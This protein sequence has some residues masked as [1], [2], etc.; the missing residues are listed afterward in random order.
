MNKR[1]FMKGASL[2]E[3]A[4]ILPR[5]AGAQALKR[6]PNILIVI[7]DD[8]D[9]SLLNFMGG[10]KGLMPHVEALTARSHR[11]VNA[12][13]LVPICQP[14]REA[15]LSGKLPHRSGATGFNPMNEGTVTLPMILQ[16]EGYFAAAIRKI[17]HML[18]QS[19]FPWDFAIGAATFARASQDR[20]PLIY[21]KGVELAIAEAQ[22]QSKPF[23][24]SC[25]I[26]DPHRPFY[27]SPGGL[28]M[29]HQN[30]G[31]YAIDHPLGPDDVRLPPCLDDLP[32]VRE[33]VAQYA[34]SAQRSDASLGRVLAALDRSGEADNTIVLFLSDNGLPFPF[35][36]ATVYDSGTRCP[37]LVTWPGMGA[38][39]AF[40][41]LVTHIDIMPTLLDMLGIAAP[42]DLDGQSLMPLMAG[43]PFADPAFQVTYVNNLAGG[44]NYPQRAIQDRRYA[45]LF[46]PWADGTLAFKAE[47]M[48][49]LSFNAMVEGAKADAKLASRVK[50][51]QYGEVESF[52]DL[53]ADP[54]QRVNLI[55][56]RKHAGVIAQMKKTLQ[57][58]MQANGDPQLDN[59]VRVQQGLPPVVI[60]DAGSGGAVEG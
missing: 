46:M 53:V 44:A 42:S 30:D 60:Q 29:D 59:F 38:P 1:S 21:E 4:G 45:Y 34:N 25:N 2:L 41:T 8:L 28:K 10:R 22:T 24:L 48:R 16:R 49:G 56:S 11:F 23:F 6:K 54:G 33:E 40:D 3:L 26:G 31:P 35:G 47:S 20:N 14:S 39:Q 50:L 32:Q 9:Y 37:F 15:L 43:G 55:R 19:S 7:A 12:R 13:A 58:Y 52:Y 36:K 51:Y 5:T 17:E 18:P 57:A 27:G